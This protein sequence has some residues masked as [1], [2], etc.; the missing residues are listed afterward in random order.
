MGVLDADGR[1]CPIQGLRSPKGY[2]VLAMRDRFLVQNRNDG[3]A[4]I[5]RLGAMTVAD[6]GLASEGHNR[7]YQKPGLLSQA[8]DLLHGRI[9]GV[10]GFRSTDERL[11]EMTDESGRTVLDYMW[12]RGE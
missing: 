1:M 4:E 6:L 12:C 3:T 5:V 2:K 9:C 11:D 8:L 7:G 10:G